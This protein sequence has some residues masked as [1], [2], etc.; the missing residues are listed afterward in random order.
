[1]GRPR[2]DKNRIT[3]AIRFDPELHAR[4]KAAADERD[5]PLNWL[6]NRAVAEFLDNLIPIEEMK[7]TR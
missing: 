4:L 1:M 7:W 2:E 5:L 6:V 3:T